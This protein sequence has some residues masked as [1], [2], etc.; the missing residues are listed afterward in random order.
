MNAL[1]QAKNHRTVI[2]GYVYNQWQN[3]IRTAADTVLK[4]C[5]R[6]LKQ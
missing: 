6:N 5:T 4:K 2:S 3:A 1:I